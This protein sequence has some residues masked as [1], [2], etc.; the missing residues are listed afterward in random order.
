MIFDDE[1]TD[2]DCLAIIKQ[3][4]KI[5]GRM[6]NQIYRNKKE[7]PEKNIDNVVN[8]F[9]VIGACDSIHAAVQSL[10]GMLQFDNVKEKEKEARPMEIEYT[11]KNEET[12]GSIFVTVQGEEEDIEKLCKHLESH[13]VE[14]KNIRPQKKVGVE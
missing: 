2:P 10:D 4:L 12:E 6:N 8:P 7:D 3:L 9:T 11:L 13:K 5:R 14:A 1:V